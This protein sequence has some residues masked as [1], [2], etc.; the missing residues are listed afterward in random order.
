VP[1]RAGPAAAPCRSQQGAAREAP[2]FIPSRLAHPR[3]W[4][5]LFLL[6]GIPA[7][8]IGCCV[9]AF[10]PASVEAARFLAPAERAALAEAVAADCASTPTGMGARQTLALLRR[11]M[12]NP[13]LWLAILANLMSSIGAQASAGGRRGSLRP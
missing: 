6:E 8:I 2:P 11:T 10:M 12:A 5:W 13:Y 1:R 4:Q 7:V 3:G 9:W